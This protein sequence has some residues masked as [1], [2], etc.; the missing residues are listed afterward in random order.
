MSNNILYK[1]DLKKEDVDF[2]LTKCKTI[3]IDTETTGLDPLN[4]KLCLMQICAKDRVYVIQEINSHNSLNIK[5]L[6]STNKVSKIF[7]HA[8]FDLR[9]LMKAL[10]TT[11]IKNVIC[12]KVAYKL[13]N[14]IKES[15]S[16]KDLIYKYLKI[17]LDKSQQTSD[18]SK[19]ILNNNQLEYA[20]NDVIYLETL[21]EHLKKELENKELLEIAYKCFDYLPINARLNNDGID[22]IFIY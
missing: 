22:N 1:R 13:I 11:D 5:Y 16:L 17:K 10:N 7:H 6:L 3:S 20:I 19:L 4:D 21:W 2:I 14:G 15:S 9:F 8:N 18:W 12:T